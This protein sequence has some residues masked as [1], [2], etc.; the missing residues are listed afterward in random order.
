M[1]DLFMFRRKPDSM[2]M[3]QMKA[4][5][6]EE[7]QR[8]LIQRNKLDREK[9]LREQAERDRAV[10]EQRLHA[11]MSHIADPNIRYII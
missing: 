5:A 1:I 10:M 11:Y 4:V 6:K 2:E 7:Q 8:R 9:Q 3:Q